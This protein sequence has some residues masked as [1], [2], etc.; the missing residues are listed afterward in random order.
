MLRVRENKKKR[1]KKKR[2]CMT[3]R[4][5]TQVTCQFYCLR[6]AQVLAEFGNIR[7]KKKFF[8]VC[9]FFSSICD[10]IRIEIDFMRYL[11]FNDYKQLEKLII[12]RIRREHSVSFGVLYR[13]RQFT[14][15]EIYT[16][17]FVKYYFRNIFM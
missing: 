17:D 1:E 9:V 5:E 11:L 3:F 8:L 15:T 2:E 6:A 10:N 14:S 16:I 7:E 4:Y 13:P 12:P